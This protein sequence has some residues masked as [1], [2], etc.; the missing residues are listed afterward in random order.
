MNENQIK[1]LLKESVENS[2][3]DFYHERIAP[4]E[5]Q[6]LSLGGT[7]QKNPDEIEFKFK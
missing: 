2:L 3:N 6:I 7:I 1:D 4:L 5:K